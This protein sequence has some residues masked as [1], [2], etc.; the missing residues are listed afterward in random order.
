MTILLT[1]WLDSFL[2]FGNFSLLKIEQI[3]LCSMKPENLDFL[4]SRTHVALPLHKSRQR[5]RINPGL[6]VV[7]RRMV[8]GSALSDIQNG[9]P[10]LVGCL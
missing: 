9:E 6:C 1:P 10:L 5:I 7:F 3:S 4:S 8:S 2:C